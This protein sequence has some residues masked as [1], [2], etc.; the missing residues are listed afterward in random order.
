MPVDTV[1]KI[2]VSIQ[3]VTVPAN[4]DAP[5]VVLRLSDDLG[6]GLTGLPASAM[7]FTLAQLSPGQNGGSSEWQ[8]Y[9]TRGPQATTESAQAGT[10]AD[11]GDGTYTYTFAQALTAYAGGPVFSGIK[12]HRL[13]V[14]IRTNR[15]LPENIPANN[16]PFDFVPAGGA[17]I[18]ERL[19]V[20]NAACNAC[21]D[22]LEVHGEARFDV[23]YCVTCH[24]PY[25]I[26][27]DTAAEPWG[28]SVDMKVM[29]HKIHYG[30]NLVNGYRVIGYNDTPHD[31]SDI[32]FPQDVRNCTTCHQESDATVPQASNWR[33]VQNRAAC[34]TCHDDIDWAAGDHP[35]GFVFTD[36]TQC[37]LCHDEAQGPEALW[38]DVVHRIPEA[39]AAKA[40]EYSIVRVTG[41]GIGEVPVI[42]FSVTDPTNDDEPYD[43]QNDSEFTTCAQ[44]TSRL[45]V[46]IAWSTTDYTNADSGN[47][48]GQP[49][50]MNPLTA[51]GGTSTAAGAGV[52]SVTSPIAVPATASG[53]LAVTIDGH[54]AVDIDGTPTRIGVTNAVA[55]APITDTSAVPRRNAVAIEKCNDCHNQLSIHGNN[56]TDNI[57]VCV[58]C[59]NPNATD[60]NR[61][62]GTC[63][64]ELGTDDVSIDMKYMIHALHAGAPPEGVP[65]D[66]CGFGFP[67]TPHTYDFVYPGRLNNCEGC[68]VPGGY[69]PVDPAAVLGTT[70][71]SGTNSTT[72][73]DD[74]V[75][76]PNSSVCS[77]CHTSELARTHMVQNG[78]D[79]NAMKNPD[80]TLIPASVETCALCH[81][82][83]RSADVG[84]VHGVGTFEFN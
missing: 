27:P 7:G 9:V 38:V 37:A 33:E 29:I 72:P 69:Y 39:E 17:P 55:Y 16:A 10:Y 31:Y 4:G 79:F 48:P 34:G 43:I 82:E 13:G 74:V 70:V 15:Y 36:D 49:V 26:D 77:S 1:E 21:H 46:G 75:V 45:V 59:H 22:N 2:N 84:V 68:H 14:E 53:T 67:S 19:I 41:T 24:N 80:S 23:E 35:G 6:F 12:T 83:G 71:D 44:G 61:R 5:T 40:F 50:S 32:V 25:S 73:I 3:S 56:R 57:E 66:V 11:N 30:E 63:A 60:I 20:N 28:G 58:T 81:G 8:S 65:Y 62:V 54:P 78:G 76:S 18:E 47:G 64:D 52:F 51:C 42:E